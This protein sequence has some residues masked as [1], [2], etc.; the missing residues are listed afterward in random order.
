VLT[1]THYDS[2]GSYTAY[3]YAFDRGRFR[4]VREAVRKARPV[5]DED[6]PPRNDPVDP[7]L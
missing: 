7:K 5:E 1:R 6:D 4:L 2:R 3:L